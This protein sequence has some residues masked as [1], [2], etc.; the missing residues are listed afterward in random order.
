MRVFRTGIGAA[1]G[2]GKAKPMMGTQEIIAPIAGTA[3]SRLGPEK[4]TVRP[5]GWLWKAE[6]ALLAV[7]RFSSATIL[8]KMRY[9]IQ[10]KASFMPPLPESR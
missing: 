3:G 2:A 8:L 5:A 6:N 7:D 9:G 4:T 1:P 10:R